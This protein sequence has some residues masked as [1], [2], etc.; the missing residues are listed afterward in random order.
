[1][2]QGLDRTPGQGLRLE[3]DLSTLLQ[4]MR[5]RTEGA[6]APSS[7]SPP[8]SCGSSDGTLVILRAQRDRQGRSESYGG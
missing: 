4:T 1:M 7:R 5:D 8:R 3:A 6:S 2:L